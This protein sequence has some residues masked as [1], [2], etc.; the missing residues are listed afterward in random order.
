MQDIQQKRKIIAVLFALFLIVTIVFIGLI[1]NE[2]RNL[3]NHLQKEY[4]ISPSNM[5][6][7]TDDGVPVFVFQEY[8][9]NIIQ[10]AAI[11][12]VVLSVLGIYA[13][14][15]TIEMINVTLFNNKPEYWNLYLMSHL[16]FSD[17]EM[18]EYLGKVLK[19]DNFPSLDEIREE[20]K[21]IIKKKGGESDE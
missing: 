19:E 8:I 4:G 6:E 11:F 16:I 17:D 13:L 20:I 15:K 5:T 12:I 7:I 21:E 1:G 9:K 10:Y 3:E 2:A 14:Y 18:R